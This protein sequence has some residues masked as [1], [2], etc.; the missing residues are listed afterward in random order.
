[1]S[2]CMHRGSFFFFLF[3]SFL[4]AIAFTEFLLYFFKLI[5]IGV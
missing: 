4:G 3:F 5:F 2:M 1:M